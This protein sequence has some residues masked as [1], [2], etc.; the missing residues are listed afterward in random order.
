VAAC[1]S[2]PPADAAQTRSDFVDRVRRRRLL[3]GK[4]GAF[5]LVLGYVRALRQPITAIGF[6]SRNLDKAL[7]VGL[8]PLASLYFTLYAIQL[9]RVSI[10]GDAPRLVF[11][12]LKETGEFGELSFTSLRLLGQLANAVMEESI[13]RGI[14]LPH[15]MR[16]AELSESECSTSPSIRP[17]AS[18]LPGQ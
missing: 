16:G 6:H 2:D 18:D 5:V 9:Y 12:A 7:L 3:A 10:A 17:R 13:F 4:R 14:M 11:G 15:L 1:E 8:V